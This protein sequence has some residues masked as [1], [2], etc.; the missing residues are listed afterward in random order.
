MEY[1][2]EIREELSRI[3][4]VNAE[5]YDEAINTVKQMYYSGEIILTSEDFK[6][7]EFC[8]MKMASDC[9][10]KELYSR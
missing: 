2:I 7:T 6:E 5:T 3:K 10:N 9:S 1:D 4:R 8:C